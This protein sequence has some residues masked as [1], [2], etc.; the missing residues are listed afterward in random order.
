MILREGIKKGAAADSY[1]AVLYPTDQTT[2][3]AKKISICK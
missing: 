1:E 3:L 2:K